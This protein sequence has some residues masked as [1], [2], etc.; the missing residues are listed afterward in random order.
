MT[1]AQELLVCRVPVVLASISIFGGKDAS[2]VV[3]ASIH[4]TSQ[5]FNIIIATLLF[6]H[7]LE[8]IRII[9][10]KMRIFSEWPSESVPKIPVPLFPNPTCR[11][12]PPKLRTRSLS[13]SRIWRLVSR[14]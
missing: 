5:L 1:T 10:I 8:T 3:A 13:N 2:R 7:C 9:G 6:V 14:K 12:L 11:L 4:T